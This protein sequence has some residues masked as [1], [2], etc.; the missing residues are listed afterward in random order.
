[1][2]RVQF[3]ALLAI[4]CLFSAALGRAADKSRLVANLESGKPQ[5]VVTYGTSL[6]DGAPW[7]RELQAALDRNYPGLARVVNSGRGAMWSGW[8]AENLDP[9]VIEKKPDTVLIEFSINDAYLPYKTS[10]P[11][12]RSNL[13]NMIE[14]ILKPNTNCEVVLMVMNPPTGVHL[15]QR[16]QIKDYNQMVR[17]V[18][19]DRKLL[20]IDHYPNWEKIL[21][22][23]PDLFK[24]YVPDGIHP[25]AEGCKMVIAPEIFRALGVKVSSAQVA[26]VWQPSE[27]RLL[28]KWGKEVKP[29]NVLPEYPRPQLM[30]AEWLNLNGLWDYCVT[31]R[32]DRQPAAYQGKIL[33]PF[34]I[35]APLSGVGRRLNSLPGRTY[36]NSL[37][38]YHRTFQVPPL[39]ESRRTWLH[40]GA[41]D[42]EATV[43]LNG[44]Q[45]GI[46]R[47]GYDGFSFDVTDALKKDG[48]N[49]LVV[50]VY[51]PTFEGG[52]PRGKQIDQPAGIFYT[53]C[54]GIWQ[55]VWLEPVAADHVESLHVVPDLDGSV[56][57]ITCQA[58]RPA[59]PVRI[60]VLD[61]GKTVA[62]AKGKAGQAL[63]IKLKKPKLWS[64]SSPFLYDLAI[65]VGDDEVKSYFGMRKV[66]V[67]PD[68]AGIT[69]ILLNNEFVLH[70]G[71]LDQG[72]WPDGIYTAPTD[73]A[74]RFDI[75][76]IKRLGF[77]LSRKHVKVEP[78]R[79]YYWADKLGLLVWQDMPCSGDGIHAK[80]P[81]YP[82]SEARRQEQFGTELRAM[83]AGRFNHPSIVSW[84]VFNEGMGLQNS[85]GY[86]LDAPIRAFMRQMAGIA[87]EDKTRAINA[88]SGAPMGQYQGWNVLDIGLGQVMDAH[89]YGTTKCLVPT[90]TRASVIGE[91]GYAKFL[92]SL[93]KYR[94]LIQDPGISGLVWTQLTDVENERNGLLSYD[95]SKFSEDPQQVAAQNALTLGPQPAGK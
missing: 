45:L 7:V 36:L 76:T 21:N 67:G 64:P 88:E 59:A 29:D 75:E 92:Q 6:T 42:W 73:E 72:Y 33:V 25:G 90:K 71:V 27:D 2:R 15:E 37:L 40:F 83:I 61:G 50:A 63:T 66:S 26:D 93:D 94:P 9:R 79:W 48:S 81:A 1:M 47:G 31:A 70:N 65:K 17:D 56:V 55:T 19:K 57:R 77:N 53:P 34:P 82:E 87:G 84:I 60:A 69:R 32:E 14:R 38:W 89:C 12:A 28:T 20:L 41:V 58:S 80:P 52:Y 35:E 4:G 49:E 74:L 10:V 3:S 43:W 85:A 78:E 39:W 91:Y 46:H 62:T 23:D 18:A 11:Q 68:K 86:Q 44:K 5:T 51:D 24:K 16:P 54:S 22:G 95:R 13:V 30:R 8:G